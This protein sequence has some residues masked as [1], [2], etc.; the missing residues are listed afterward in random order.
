M[1]YVREDA[2]DVLLEQLRTALDGMPECTLEADAADG[3]CAALG[4][5]PVRPGRPLCTCPCPHG[6]R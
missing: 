2:V 3:F 6:R 1:D 4:A 5:P